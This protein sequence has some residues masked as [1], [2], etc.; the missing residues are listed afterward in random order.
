MSSKR[1]FRLLKEHT[2]NGIVHPAGSV[3]TLR[4]NTGNGLCEQGIA[5]KSVI[6]VRSYTFAAP[7]EEDDQDMVDVQSN[8]EVNDNG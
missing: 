7:A 2:I 8:N 1:D 5:E 6:A 4:E 3:V